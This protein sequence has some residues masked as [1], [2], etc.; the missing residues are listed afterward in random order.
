MCSAGVESSNSSAQPIYRHVWRHCSWRDRRFLRSAT[1]SPTQDRQQANSRHNFATT[2]WWHHELEVDFSAKFAS[3]VAL[4]FSQCLLLLC[5]WNNVVKSQTFW[6]RVCRKTFEHFKTLID[7]QHTWVTSNQG[8]YSSSHAKSN[9]FIIPLTKNFFALDLAKMLLRSSHRIIFANSWPSYAIIAL[10]R[11]AVAVSLERRPRWL[12]QYDRSGIDFRDICKNNIL[13]SFWK[14]HLFL[15]VVLVPTLKLNWQN[16]RFIRGYVFPCLAE[17]QSQ[18][19][20]FF[21][22]I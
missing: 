4:L 19:L 1:P 12:L 13:C 8:S 6:V 10:K 18:Q 14:G 11:R 9:V 20:Q 22:I 16:L 5:Y 3:A 15:L 17:Y 21:F 2:G 7:I